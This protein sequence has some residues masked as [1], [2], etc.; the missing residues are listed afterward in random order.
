MLVAL[1]AP[2]VLT[3]SVS[4]ALL[5]LCII[6]VIIRPRG[7]SVAWFAGGGGAIA[8]ALGLLSAS[9][10]GTI[11]HDT[12][13]AAATLI[14]LFVLAETL[15]ANG[16]FSWAALWLARAAGGSGAR[17]YGL[18]LLLTTGVAALLANDGAIL[19][20]TPIY[21]KLLATIYPD[22]RI[23]LPYLFALEFLAD[24]MSAL[25]LP[26]NLTNII[27]GDASGLNPARVALWMIAPAV[28]AFIVAG[29]AFAVRFRHRLTAR[30]DLTALGDPRA[31]IRDIPLFRVG[32]VALGAL[33]TGYIAGSYVGWPVAYSAMTVALGML[34]LT[35]WRKARPASATLRAAPWSILIYAAGMFALITAAHNAGALNF[36]TQPLTAQF[37]GEGGVRGALVAA[38][39]LA[40]LSA[41]VNNLPAALVGVLALPTHAVSHLAVYAAILGLDIGPKLTPFGSLAT[42]LW[43]RLLERNGVTITWGHFMR[44][45][46]WVTLLT[47][48]AALMTL[49]VVAPILG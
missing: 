16:F 22:R 30:Y 2:S 17:L 11:L 42:L 35:H 10:L 34:A 49:I 38:G 28:A 43:F 9:A 8:L 47:L 6:L 27:V 40:A 41:T 19:M 26:S 46:W 36:F 24:A 18:T 23:Q 12:W 14:A 25:F 5:I 4:A 37:R 15:D 33:V 3:M 48:G 32:W 20:L 21:A 39:A 29:G 7:S 45:N 44:E 31:A 1:R 13:D